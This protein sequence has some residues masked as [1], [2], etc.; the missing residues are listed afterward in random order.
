MTVIVSVKLTNCE[1]EGQTKGRL[2]NPEV[3]PFVE[4]MVY[5]KLMC[6]L[7]ENPAEAREIFD[8]S[9]AAQ[10]AREA[11]K[12][13]RETARRKSA[14]NSASLFGEKCSTLRK[15]VSIKYTETKSLCLS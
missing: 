5:E 13:A 14:M 11:A 1:F 3:R 9:M 8:K 4:N 12:K 15:R 10:R 2:G 7:E 6:Y